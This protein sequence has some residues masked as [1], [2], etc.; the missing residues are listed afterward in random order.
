M[1][2]YHHLKRFWK[3]DLSGV[4]NLTCGTE[5]FEDGIQQVDDAE[6]LR[7]AHKT[8]PM[9]RAHIEDARWILQSLQTNP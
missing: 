5:Q 8:L 4:M 9:L 3:S 2:M 1:Q 6:V 7:W